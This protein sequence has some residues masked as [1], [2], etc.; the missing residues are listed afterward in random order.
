MSIAKKAATK[1]FS[2]SAEAQR[3]FIETAMVTA[4]T[5]WEEKE[6][7]AKEKQ[8]AKSIRRFARRGLN[9]TPGE[10]MMPLLRASTAE[11][12]TSATGESSAV[13]PSKRTRE[14]E[15]EEFFVKR[16]KQDP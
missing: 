4:Q 9:V 12:G 7:Q 11:H 6:I 5:K 16:T 14:E 10:R 1:S 13:G 2:G 3:A 15:G 8:T